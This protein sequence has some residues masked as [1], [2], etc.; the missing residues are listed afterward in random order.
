[1]STYRQG[2]GHIKTVSATAPTERSDGTPLSAGEID[3]YARFLT[4]D[5][6]Q[7]VEQAVALVNGAFDEQIDIDAATPGIY[8]YWY[9]TV[10]TDGRRSVDSE[11]VT[12]EILVPLVAPSPPTNF[13]FG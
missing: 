12:L 10:D 13:L 1:M 3:Y 7:P 6:G 4:F 11:R 5:G 2:F 8:E 9:Q